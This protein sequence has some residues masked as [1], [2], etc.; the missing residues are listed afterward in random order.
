MYTVVQGQK[1]GRKI[2]FPTLNLEPAKIDADFGIYPCEVFFENGMNLTGVLHYGKRETTDN[3]LSL[4]VHLFD[5]KKKFYGKK[6]NLKIGQ[7]IREIRKFQN[8]EKL[9][10]QIQKDI[11]QV[12]K[13]Y[14]F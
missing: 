2:G 11:K 7:K 5:F 8:L 3:K 13:N 6:V 12:Q 10:E 4:E 1:I 9:K 14:N